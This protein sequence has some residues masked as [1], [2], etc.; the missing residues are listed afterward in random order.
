LVFENMNNLPPFFF[1]FN[2]EGVTRVRQTFETVANFD[3]VAAQLVSGT[4]VSFP[5]AFL[6]RGNP[7][8]L[9]KLR[10]DFGFAIRIV[11]P[12]PLQTNFILTK[13]G[14]ELSI[15]PSFGTGWNKEANLQA[16]MGQGEHLVD[17][18]IFQASGIDMY[19]IY[20]PS[21]G[22]FLV[23]KMKGQIYIPPLPNIHETAQVCTGEGNNDFQRAFTFWE[24]ADGLLNS[25]Y[26]SRWN[27]DLLTK[28]IF[29][30][31]QRFFR[32]SPEGNQPMKSVPTSLKT[33]ELRVVSTEGIV[34]LFG[35]GL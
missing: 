10:D 18:Q 35:V 2:E 27:A 4:P 31:A 28:D 19:L 11:E 32:W 30:G 14:S 1:V 22:L 17:P 7:V 26:A 12:F 20:I 15:T 34:Q 3:Y 9:F 23:W 16:D 33:R 8:T 25:F 24:K 29:H 5:T 21:A 13:E 6:A